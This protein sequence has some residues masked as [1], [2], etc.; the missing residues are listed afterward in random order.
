MEQL[1]AKI[2]GYLKIL[3]NNIEDIEADNEGLIDF[4]IAEVIDRVQLYLNSE[5]IPKQIERIIANIVNTGIKKTLKEKTSEDVEQVIT[6]VS[7]NGQSIAYAN[8]IK[9]YFTSA[10]DDEV[11]AGFTSLLARYRR[12]KVVYPENNE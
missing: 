7:D 5:T 1:V 6:S 12:I 9:K 11:F 2:K 8:E 4:V 10:S 3:N